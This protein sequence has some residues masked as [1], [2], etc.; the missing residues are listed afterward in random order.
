MSYYEQIMVALTVTMILQ[1]GGM[2]FSVFSDRYI[3]KEQKKLLV[4]VILVALSIVIQNVASD[5]SDKVLHNRVL[6]LWLDIYGYSA[7]P[8]MLVLFIKLLD[9]GKKLTGIMILVA[10]NAA[11]HLTALFSDICFTIDEENIFRRGTLGAASFIIS[12]ILI[13]VLM[14]RVVIMFKDKDDKFGVIIPVISSVIIVTSVIADIYLKENPFISF[15]T[16]AIVFSA[17][18]YYIWLHLQFE[19]EHEDALITEQ[20]MQIM[21]SQIQPH[22]LYNTLSTIQALCRIDP[23][24]AFDTAGKFGIYLRQNIDSLGQKDMIP[25]IKELEHTQ[26]YAEIEQIRFPNI[27]LTYDIQYNDFSI[28]VLTV[29]PIV[30]NAIR[31]GVRIREKGLVNISTRKIEDHVE[32][33]ISDNGIG[34]DVTDV[35]KSDRSHIGMQN[36]R[37]RLMELCNGTFEVNSKIYEGTTVTICIPLTDAEKNDI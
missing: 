36:V 34:F 32:I 5:Y 22:F 13:V 11:I 28:P 12:A 18:F 17:T 1:L 3:D 9:T 14:Y 19:R 24:K 6:R 23:D 2:L 27:T 20:K 33:V 16:V 8:I 7:R 29:Q 10:I 30:E 4:T 31:H 37:D 25:F 35:Q 15:L 21:V 26:V